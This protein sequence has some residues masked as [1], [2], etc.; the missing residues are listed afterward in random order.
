VGSRQSSLVP[1][2]PYRFIE[3]LRPERTLARS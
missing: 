2:A 3:N 1:D